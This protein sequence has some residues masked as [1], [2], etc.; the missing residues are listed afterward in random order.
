M[1]RNSDQ[2]GNSEKEDIALCQAVHD[3]FLNIC[4]V[5][6]S[7]KGEQLP[8]PSELDMDLLLWRRMYVRHCS[9]DFRH[10]DTELNAVKTVAQWNCDVNC[11]L[12]NQPRKQLKWK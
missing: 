2:L 11:D 12:K 5:H 10:S 8:I 6:L 1:T 7:Q 9:G 4:G 3:R